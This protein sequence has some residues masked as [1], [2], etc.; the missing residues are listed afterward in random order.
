MADVN[1]FLA[2]G[3]WYKGAMH[4]HTTRS[5]GK[6]SP[7]E[8][9]AF[10]R[11]HGYH[12][13]S[14]TDH[15]TITDLSAQ[16]TADFLNIPGVE[17]SHGHNEL[18]QSYH[19]VLIGTRELVHPSNALSVQDAINMWADKTQMLFLAHPYWSGHIVSEMMPLQRLDGVEIYNTSS[20][21]D[22]GKGLA[23]VLWDEL[24]VRGKHWWGYAVDDTHGVND[25][26]D[27]GWVVVKSEKLDEQSIIAAMK[28]GAFYA[29]SGPQIQ[30]FR[31]ENGVATIKCSPVATINFIGHTQWGFQ[32][33]A[34][35]GKTITDA[36][37]QLTGHEH[38]LRAEC[39]D[40]GGHA[41]WTNPLVVK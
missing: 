2:P 7:A 33:R 21:T 29:S 34:E 41:A 18:G 16:S 8:S 35:P 17:V 4:V 37:W 23:T 22:L 12:F 1:P 14:V 13:L 3:S 25:D 40:G 9:M 6:L 30:D 24:L 19:V 20:W 28:S 39:I 15:G 5:D 38:Y 27:G 11:D 31:V 36:R 10:H 32:R 26:A